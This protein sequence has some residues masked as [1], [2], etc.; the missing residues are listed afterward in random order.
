MGMRLHSLQ[1]GVGLAWIWL[2]VDLVD[3]R[4]DHHLRLDHY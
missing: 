3:L 1:K 2:L 4:T